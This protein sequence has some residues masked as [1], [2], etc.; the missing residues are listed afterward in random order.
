M[1]T[2]NRVLAV[3]LSLVL[4]CVGVPF[5][6][7][8][9]AEIVDSGTCGSSLTWTLDSEG[10]LTIA[11]TGTM[12]NFSSSTGSTYY[13]GSYAWGS[14]RN[15]IKNVVIGDSV[16][17]I[18][19]SA[20]RDCTSLES[21][22]IGDSVTSIGIEAFRD[23]TALTNVTI[24][25]SMTILG[26]YV[27]NNCSSLT[28]VMLPNS[29]QSIGN[30]AFYKCIALENIIIPNEVL[31]IGEEAFYT[32]TMLI[33]NKDSYAAQWAKDTNY[34]FCYIDA[35]SNEEN[36][37]HE[38]VNS[39]LSY[40][41]DKLSRTLYVHGTGNMVSFGEYGAPWQ[42]YSK[43][44][45]HIIIDVGCLSVGNYAFYSM[46]FL[47]TAT[48]PSTIQTIGSYAFDRCYNLDSVHLS[49]GLITMSDHAF[50]RC[51]K[52]ESILFPKGLEFIGSYAFY[53]CYSLQEIILPDSLKTIQ[54]N[55]AFSS[56]SSLRRVVLGDGIKEIG[57]M[58]FSNCTNL[59]NVELGANISY[60]DNTAFQN[61]NS[62]ESIILPESLK[63]INSQTFSLTGLRKIYIHA[64]DCSIASN[65]IYY[66]ATIYGHRGGTVEAF[67]D[68]YGFPFVSLDAGEHEHEFG[69]WEPHPA[70][71]CTEDGLLIRRCEVCG[72]REEE[73]LPALGHDYSETVVDPT[74]TVTGYTTHVCARCG[75][76]YDDAFTDALGHDWQQGDTIDPTCEAEGYTMYACARCGA[77]K[78]EDQVPALG[79]D[80]QPGET[81][82]PTC[83]AEGYTVYTC[84]R[85]GGELWQDFTP[86]IPHVDE[87]DDGLCDVCEKRLQYRITEN[88][89][90]RVAITG[91]QLTYIRFIPALPGVATITSVS[92]EDT[93]GYLF[94]ANM[95]QIASDDDGGSGNNFL[96]TR[97]MNAGEVYYIGVRYYSSGR[98]GSFEV[99]VDYKID[100]NHE[101]TEPIPAVEPTCEDFGYTA[102][103]RCAVCGEVL[104][105]QTP[106][107]P[108]KHDFA[109]VSRKEP[110]ETETGFIKYACVRCGV[111][112]QQKLPALGHDWQ[113]VE[114]TEPTCEADGYKLYQC[115]YEDCDETLRETVPALGHTYGEWVV[116]KEPTCHAVGM[117]MSACTRCELAKAQYLPKLEH[118]VVTDAAVEP[119]CTSYGLTEGSHC[120]LCGDVFTA[121]ELLP[122]LPHTEVYVDEIPATCTQ[123]GVS[124][125]VRCEV[126]GKAL[127]GFDPLPAL[128]HL[129][130]TGDGFPATCTEDGRTDR[131]YCDR[132][133]VVFQEAE[134]I[135]AF[136]HSYQ[137]SDERKETCEED[138]Y[139][140]YT[141][142]R[143]G[144]TYTKV[145]P[146]RGHT[147]LEK[148]VAP[149]CE[150][151]GFTEYYCTKCT[152]SYREN[153]TGALG[154]DYVNASAAPK[155]DGTHVF[156][157][158]RCKQPGEPVPCVDDNL[159]EI[160]D[161][162]GQPLAHTHVFTNY[163]PDGNATCLEDGTKTAICDLCGK[164]K[165]TVTDEGSHLTAPHQHE[166]VAM[167]DATCTTNA[168]RR[169][170]CKRC[171]AETIGE[172]PDSALGHAESGWLY[173]EG[174]DCE[175]GGS[176]Y[177]TCTRCGQVIMVEAIAAR[178]HS[179][180]IDPEVPRTCT[181]DGKSAGTHCEICGK[182]IVAQEV[183]PKTGHTDDN[184][185]G[186]CDNC[187]T[188]LREPEQQQEEPQTF[189]QKIGAFFRNL[190]DKIFGIFRR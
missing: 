133:G 146:A 10:T 61:C 40:T 190:F 172:I 89:T 170:V 55:Y 50:S 125:G 67:A 28:S 82:A 62:I 29:L 168:H 148:V 110:T 121:Q 78:A 129:A 175:A 56:C 49:D 3:L 94:D 42:K 75:D 140:T 83:T 7:A 22:T 100:C 91:G 97:R 143:C 98:S 113:L 107:E 96:L 161:L 154:H 25:D 180:V 68:Q 103:V 126:C 37:I 142:T 58:T 101:T 12:R 115:A 149:T 144:D 85:C 171:G 117:T 19:D 23:C 136:G 65:A 112:T 182:I 4:L 186:V 169:G 47:K 35:E 1:K 87:D 32:S 57:Y 45:F 95:N 185:D 105:G 15:A 20:F 66:R 128:G 178:A 187:G 157:C 70:A 11:G 77:A 183:I 145:Y 72:E 141:C 73:V 122:M 160:C 163:V 158:V 124:A 108:L 13:Y 174:F 127:S 14:R 88:Q 71:T 46:D 138:G 63:M 76:R 39:K 134:K 132:C 109:E 111:T 156:L 54:I 81:V 99:R 8:E 43:Y 60:I 151:G 118:A 188:V 123:K 165:D 152:Y 80:W 102:G 2:T 5:A 51:Y 26:D 16:T 90:I 44:I 177:K 147:L 69:A 21:V 74:C 9:G 18:G 176:R 166:W 31:E 93:Y 119:T 135:A 179:E 86:T 64:T 159:D 36:Q 104:E 120:I 167:N 184:D 33:C 6:A 173:P 30:G 38:V 181:T 162:C 27:F 164:A 48:L 24:P 131:T 17:S 116:T 79:H 59:K 150:N 84:T 34:P 189:F 52:L 137:I 139:T 106:I 114:E 153:E 53:S 41:V 92:N 155:G 130:V